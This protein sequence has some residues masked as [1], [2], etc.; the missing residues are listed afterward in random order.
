[1]NER[2]NL[3]RTVTSEKRPA[4]TRTFDSWPL[5]ALFSMNMTHTNLQF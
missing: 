5:L 3:V 1:M 2:K 4:Q